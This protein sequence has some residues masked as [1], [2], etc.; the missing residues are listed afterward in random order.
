MKVHR[1]TVSS[2]W[3]CYED[4]SF[5]SALIE[6]LCLQFLSQQHGKYQQTHTNLLPHDPGS[7]QLD[8]DALSGHKSLCRTAR[9]TRPSAGRCTGSRGHR[10]V[11]TLFILRV[12]TCLGSCCSSCFIFRLSLYLSESF[13]LYI[14]QLPHK[15]LLL[16]CVILFQGFR[17]AL[18]QK[19]QLTRL[20]NNS[21]TYV[22]CNS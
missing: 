16:T 3:L 8:P 4:F 17:L 15:F 13:W 1:L 14:W 11:K 20:C 22:F 18:R 6:W 12:T 2:W 7:S 21:L 10:R 5:G 9:A 19:A